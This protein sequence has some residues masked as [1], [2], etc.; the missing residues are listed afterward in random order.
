MKVGHTAAGVRKI[1]RTRHAHKTDEK[2]APISL[3]NGRMSTETQTRPPGAQCKNG[4]HIKS[5][6]FDRPFHV[7]SRRQTTEALDVCHSTEAALTRRPQMAR[8]AG[9]VVAMATAPSA[10]SCTRR[11]IHQQAEKSSFLL[12]GSPLDLDSLI[13]RRLPIK[14]TLIGSFHR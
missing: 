13:G 4:R 1:R 11:G 10:D 7:H 8:R 12:I 5:W 14:I 3:Q 9:R 2:T 6:P